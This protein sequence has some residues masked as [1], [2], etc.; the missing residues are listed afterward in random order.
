GAYAY[1]LRVT[2]HN[3]LTTTLPITQNVS[4]LS[5]QTFSL[6]VTGNPLVYN[7][8]YAQPL[9]VLGGT[10]IYP[11]WTNQGPLPPRLTLNAPNG[12]VRGAPTNTGFF[13]PPF[14]ATDSSGN[15]IGGNVSFNVSGPTGTTLSFLV[16]PN[17][18]PIAVGSTASFTMTPS[19]TGAV[20]P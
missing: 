12:V 14:R 16:G 13:N 19:A 8:P 17:L 10:G 18:G 1:V 15:P 5:F 4:R 7:Q 2:D 3:G 9:L 11:T 6:P 20:P